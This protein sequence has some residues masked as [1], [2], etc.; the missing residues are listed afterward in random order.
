MPFAATWMGLEITILSEVSPTEED[1]DTNMWNLIKTTQHNL[2]NIN[3]LKDFETKFTV[4]K[5][6]M[7]WGGINEEFGIDIY[8]LLCIRQG[9][10]TYCIAQGNLLNTV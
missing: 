1:R 3:G 7:W 6:E 8:T 2:Q 5:G 9:A 4:A 10:R